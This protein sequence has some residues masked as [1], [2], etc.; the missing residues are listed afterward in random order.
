MVALD[1]RVAI[2]NSIDIECKYNILSAIGG[3]RQ[4][5]TLIAMIKQSEMRSLRLI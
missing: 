3:N 2:G 1:V 5:T 4:E